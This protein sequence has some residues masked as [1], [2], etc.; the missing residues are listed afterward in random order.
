M[1]VFLGGGLNCTSAFL[2]SVCSWLYS[3]AQFYGLYCFMLVVNIGLILSGIL[4][5]RL[6]TER[7]KNDKTAQVY[8]ALT[9]LFDS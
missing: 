4:S 8:K 3:T 9:K 1:N 6:S 5:V 2:L 7:T